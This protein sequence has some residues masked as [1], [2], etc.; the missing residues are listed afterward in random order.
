MKIQLVLITACTLLS[1]TAWGVPPAKTSYLAGRPILPC[2]YR[3]VPAL[4]ATLP[5][6]I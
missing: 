4:I 2:L 3:H 1:M 5:R 6:Q